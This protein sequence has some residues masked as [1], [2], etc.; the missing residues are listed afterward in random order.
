[1]HLCKLI[2]SIAMLDLIVPRYLLCLGELRV[3]WT[4]ITPRTVME[5]LSKIKP[6]KMCRVD[7][8]E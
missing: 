7:S 3:I 8:T 5:R 1:M 6:Y 4:G 2:R